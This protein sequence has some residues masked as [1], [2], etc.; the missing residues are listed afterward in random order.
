M[1]SL[2]PSVHQ[3]YAPNSHLPPAG[4]SALRARLRGPSWCP[5]VL[6]LDTGAVKNDPNGVRPGRPPLGSVAAGRLACLVSVW[7]GLLINLCG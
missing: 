7:S 4:T 3:L 1:H 6:L 2:P 5:Q